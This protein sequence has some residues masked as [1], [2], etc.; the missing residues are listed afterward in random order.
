MGTMKKI[1]TIGVVAF[2]KS[3]RLDNT[4][5]RIQRWALDSGVAV[6]FHPLLKGRVRDSGR[7]A[8]SETS[9]LA[10]SD[11]FL[12][13][14]G[15][16]TFLSMVHM[17][18]FSTKPVAGVN[19]GGLGFLTGIGEDD[20]EDGLGRIAAG[21]F[22]IV[23]RMVLDIELRRRGRAVR[24]CHA[25]NDLFVNRSGRPR[26]LSIGAWH[27]RDFIT[28]FQ[29]DGVIVATPSGSTAYSLAAGGPIVEPTVDAFLL[30]P[31]CPHSLTERPM[32]LPSGRPIRLR[33]DPGDDD[34]VM[35][36]DGLDT[37]RLAGKD[38]IIVSRSNE[39]AAIMQV[40]PLTCFDLLRRKLNWGRNYK[41]RDAGPDAA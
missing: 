32:V 40:S 2:K 15:D 25:L 16:G 35:S 26:L 12:S 13:L 5:A 34:A 39:R 18:R 4:L 21:R 1:R 38:E 24:R 20:L 37:V 3:P 23:R 10:A 7:A 27:G 36:A 28:N 33:V 30:A 17:C 9:F 31:I 29:G 19:L 6:L 8:R 14:G 22:A 41:Q 11:A